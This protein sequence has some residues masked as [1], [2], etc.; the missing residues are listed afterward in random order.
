MGYDKS[1]GLWWPLFNA[2]MKAG[3]VVLIVAL[4]LGCGRLMAPGY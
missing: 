4:F 2:L 1:I 3:Y